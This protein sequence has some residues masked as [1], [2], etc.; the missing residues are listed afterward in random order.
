MPAD[1]AAGLVQAASRLPEWGAA[2]HQHACTPPLARCRV[3][4]YGEG[5]TPTDPAELC[6]RLLCSVYMGTEVRQR[7]SRD[8]IQKRE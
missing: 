5:E 2:E 8:G 1:R 3:G 4:Q 6:T 7:S